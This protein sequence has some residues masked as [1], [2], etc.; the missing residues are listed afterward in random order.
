MKLPA[1][2]LVDM[3]GTIVDSEPYW[4]SSEHALVA[5]HG[6]TWSLEDAHS[7]VGFDLLDVGVELRDRGGVALEPA[8][9]VERLL[10]SVI[11][12]C[13]DELLW[14][15][16]ARE[17]LIAARDAGVPCVLVTMSW[18]RLA[19]AVLD[20][21]PAGVFVGSVTGDEVTNGKPAPDPYLAAAELLGLPPAECVAIEDSPTGVASAM[22]AG[23]RTVAVPHVV[24]VEPRPGLT[25]LDTLEGVG[26][27]DLPTR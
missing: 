21:A 24:D 7:I 16:G 11:A 2:L 15:P 17:L 10:D 13:A 5:E 12:K 20:A 19:E 3:D 4:I 9:I 26:I 18:R 23:C 14:R 1:A 25:I 27:S 22:A 6:G 8:E